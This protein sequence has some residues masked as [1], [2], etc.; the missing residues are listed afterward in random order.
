MSWFVPLT[1]VI[2]LLS[3]VVSGMGGGGGGFIT[4]PYYLFIGLPPANALATAKMGGIGTSIGAMT[5]LRGKGLVHKKLVVPFMVLTVIFSLISA[6]LIPRIDPAIFQRVIA[7]VLI[8][9]TPTLFI[10]KAAF[11]PG[12]RSRP[13]IIV[14]FIC[15]A[16]F[17]FLQTLVG[18]GMGSILV[19]ILMFLFG[20]GAMEANATKRVAQSLQS[21]ILFVLL[22][23]Q[24]L[25]FW[26][27]GLAGLAGSL[28]GSHIGTHIAIKKGARFVK[29]MLAVVMLTSGI[30]LLFE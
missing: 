27:H 17:S 8:V 24:G 10:K 11:Q 22:A 28:I 30:A 4:I 1:F 16:V 13:F 26:W 25:V 18:T 6:Y 19:L 15:Y 21:V 20:L 3:S 9:L 23:I 2:G 7:I 14:G 29:I 12:E 5:A